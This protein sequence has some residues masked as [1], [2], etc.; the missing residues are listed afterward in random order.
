[1]RNKLTWVLFTSGLLVA[2]GF[3][4]WVSAVLLQ[5]EQAQAQTTRDAIANEN[6]QL[7]LWQM[8]NE[9]TPLVTD[10]ATRP[11]FHYL[12]FYPAEGAYSSM[13]NDPQAGD[14]LLPSPLLIG[15]AAAVIVHF[16]FA[17]DGT[18]TS[19]QV[20]TGDL[21][22][23]AEDKLVSAADLEAAEQ[24][25]ARLGAIA[26]RDTLLPLLPRP[27]T[28]PRQAVSREYM[29]ANEAW[30]SQNVANREQYE[31]R[32]ENQQQV[33]DRK[34]AGQYAQ[35]RNIKAEPIEVVGSPMTAMWIGDSLLLARRVE[36][37][38]REYV[39]GALLDWPQLK[40]DLTAA[41]STLMPSAEF[42]P[43]SRGA[44]ATEAA[45][46]QR[47]ASLPIE[48]IPGKLPVGA[49]DGRSPLRLTMY[50]AW[51]C[52]VL[53]AF[54]LG[55]VMHRTLSLAQRRADFVSAVSH[56]LRTPLTTFRMYTEML[57]AGMVKDED[58][59]A[60][61]LNTLHSESLRLGHLVENV[62]AYARLENSSSEDRIQRMPV[63]DLLE[64]ASGRLKTRC[65]QAGMELVH[66]PCG[67]SVDVMADA[68]AVEQI[69][70]NLVDNACKY[71]AGGND[72]RIHV[73]CSIGDAVEIRVTDHGPGI[74]K[75]EATRMF[76]PF[77]KSAVAAANSAPGVGLGLALSRRLAKAMGGSL[78]LEPTEI[79]SKFVLKLPKA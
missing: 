26:S 32:S 16:Q 37:G 68:G 62:L 1:M 30:A 11:Y 57:A 72:K 35:T 76:K 27:E 10:E 8:E 55:F 24:R 44:V 52:L 29:Y 12:S 63:A 74:G 48:V 9:L 42:R 70:F 2:A 67:D 40:L 31:Q 47:L 18:L 36:L 49:I 41:G 17:P 6:I 64:R 39:Q 43:V 79:G 3:M 28:T 50:V 46:V 51:A 71:A 75:S 54:G 69:V 23:L 14:A 56:E 21:R 66:E 65:E 78:T 34:L 20:P 59:R 60:H 5:L 53:V 13:F 15:Q 4:A 61:Y 22:R 73:T 45:G 7:A 19:P 25:L 77:R 38:G 33:L 58:A